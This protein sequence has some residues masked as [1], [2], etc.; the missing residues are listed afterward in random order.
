LLPDSAPF[1]EWLAVEREALKRRALEVLQR[2]GEVYEAGG[3]SEQALECARRMLSLEPWLEEGHRRVMRLLAITGKRIE[4]LAQFEACKRELQKELGVEPEE[5]TLRLYEQIRGGGLAAPA[6]LPAFLSA[7]DTDPRDLQEARKPL[8]AA[9]QAELERLEQALRRT[10]SGQG[11]V[12]FV[13]GGPGMG[14]TALA[15]EFMH[16]AQTAHP[17][18]AVATGSC[19]AYFGMGDPYLPFREILEMLTGGVEERWAAGTITQEHA[20]RLWRLAPEAIR[21]VAEHGPALV[22]TFL[23]GSAL[24]ERASQAVQGAPAWLSKLHEIAGY[25]HAMQ[26][27]GAGYM[28]SDLLDPKA[29]FEALQ[30]AFIWARASG[31]VALEAEAYDYLGIKED[32]RSLR[33][34]ERGLALARWAGLKERE[35]VILRHIGMNYM[36]IDHATALKYLEES[37]QIFRAL[38][39][40]NQEV[41]SLWVAGW[42]LSTQGE[43]ARG[44]AYLEQSRQLCRQVGNRLDEMWALS[45]LTNRYMQLGC[46]GDLSEVLREAVEMSRDI[47]SVRLET[48]FRFSLCLIDWLQGDA[49]RAL[50]FAEQILEIAR[51]WIPKGKIFR[52]WEPKILAYHGLFLADMGRPEHAVDAFTQAIEISREIAYYQGLSVALA[53]LAR[54]ALVRGETTQAMAYSEEIL[55]ILERETRLTDETFIVFWLSLTCYRVLQASSDPRV[56]DVLDKA[57]HGL[58]ERAAKIDDERFRRSFLENLPWHREIIALWE[59]REKGVKK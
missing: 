7:G 20:Q 28:E 25:R 21:A 33:L 58:Q 22:E 56:G 53:G 31:L 10:I 23:P 11:Q 19:Q 43:W 26:A 52:W 24:I 35:G 47:E 29:Q 39:N 46:L 9:R 6:S 17:D 42:I 54:L 2:L 40:R 13:T 49:P 57:Y 8:F 12:L 16:R 32:E 55:L 4:A 14:K 51:E 30:M 3:E 1:E 15:Q 18:L 37:L 50:A 59:G 41:Q 44:I 38:G 27:S 48:G 36:D 45:A 34:K 5:A